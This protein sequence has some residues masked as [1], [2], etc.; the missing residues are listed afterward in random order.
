[1]EKLRMI[2]DSMVKDKIKDTAEQ[3]LALEQKVAELTD[4]LNKLQQ[5]SVSVKEPKQV[6]EVSNVVEIISEAIT[7]SKMEEHKL[8]EN[9]AT[10]LMRTDEPDWTRLISTG[11]PVLFSIFKPPQ[12]KPEEKKTGAANNL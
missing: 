8:C 9:L 7:Q 5:D 2:V 6:P 11:L 4:R 3:V 12:P 1:M 10:E